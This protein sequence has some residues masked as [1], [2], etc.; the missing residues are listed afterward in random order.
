VDT[1]D[2]IQRSSNSKENPSDLQDY[3]PS[4]TQEGDDPRFSLTGKSTS[5]P[6]LTPL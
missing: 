5:D 3:C 2:S 4:P 1:R 6:D